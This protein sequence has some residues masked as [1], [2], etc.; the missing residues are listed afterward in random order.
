[1]FPGEI[2]VRGRPFPCRPDVFLNGEC[3]RGISRDGVLRFQG[4][5][6]GKFDLQESDQEGRSNTT[7]KV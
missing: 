2:P 6:L 5:G 4:F 3:E 1:M 7:E